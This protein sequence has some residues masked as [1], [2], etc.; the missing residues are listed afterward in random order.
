MHF[1]PLDVRDRNGGFFRELDENWFV[2]QK[3]FLKVLNVL[4]VFNGSMS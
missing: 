3:V 2:N 1:L 4:T